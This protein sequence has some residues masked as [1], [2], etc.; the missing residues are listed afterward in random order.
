MFYFGFNS[1]EFIIFIDDSLFRP[2]DVFS[3]PA[4]VSLFDKISVGKSNPIL[5][6]AV[7]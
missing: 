4:A 2:D 1:K 3:N 7:F 5:L 6:N